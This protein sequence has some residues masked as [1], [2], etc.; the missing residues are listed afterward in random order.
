MYLLYY[1]TTVHTVSRL[2]IF[3]MCRVRFCRESGARSPRED[4][5]RRAEPRRSWYLVDLEVAGSTAVRQL[6]GHDDDVVVRYVAVLRRSRVQNDHQPRIRHNS[7]ERR[8]VEL[9]RS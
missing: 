3:R 6:V 2:K 9:R 8:S 5:R 4:R 1:Y 7:I